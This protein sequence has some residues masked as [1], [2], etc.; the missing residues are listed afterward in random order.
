MQQKLLPFL[1]IFLPFSIILFS[2]QF[3]LVEYVLQ[4]ELFYSTLAIYSFHILA[5]FLVYLLL[6]FVNRSFKGKTGFAF[7]ACSLLKMFAAV[8]FLLPMMLNEE[9]NPVQ[10]LMAFFIPY[11]LYLIF[12]TVYAVR[13][14][15]TK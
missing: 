3:V 13:L 4:L 8:I 14:I 7:M 9:Q 6:V 15:N 10:A 11:F 2:L 5:T 1:K 12:E